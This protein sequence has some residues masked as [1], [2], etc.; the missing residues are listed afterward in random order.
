VGED[1][2]VDVLEHISER[3]TQSEGLD[4][5]CGQWLEFVEGVG[6][7]DKNVNRARPQRS[8]IGR[9]NLENEYTKAM[10]LTMIQ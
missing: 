6:Q 4:M 8:E 7:E 2:E 3:E 1:S 9:A 10:I 5:P